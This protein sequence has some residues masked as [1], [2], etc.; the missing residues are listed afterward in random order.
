MAKTNFL[1]T[2]SEMIKKQLNDLGISKIVTDTLEPI[3]DITIIAL[4][5]VVISW[6]LYIIARTALKK[7]L[8]HKEYIF[9]KSILHFNVLKKI[10]HILFPIIV[11]WLLPLAFIESPLLQHYLESIL[12][13]YTVVAITITITALLDT[14]GETAFNN[15][16]Y[17]NRPIKGFVQIAKMIIYAISAI[18]VVSIIINKSPLYLIGGLGAFA[19]VFMLITKDSIMGFVG[20]YLLLENDMIRL[21]DWIEVPGSCI[22]GI[23][24]DISL[25]IVKV[26]N[27]DNT[28]A[29]IPPYTLINQSF[30]NW[31]GIDELGARRIVRN[32]F[33]KLDCIQPATITFLNEIKGFDKELDEY[34]EKFK[35]ADNIDNLIHSEINGTIESN[36][37]IFRAYSQIY[38][39]RHPLLR[40]DLLTMVRTLDITSNGLPIQFYCFAVTTDW[41]SYEAI[42][43]EIIEH[44]ISMMPKFGLYAAQNPTSYDTVISGFVE[45]N[46]DIE[47]IDGMPYGM[48]KR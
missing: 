21:G 43:T 13:I 26:R 8:K 29:T 19:A 23:V 7:V 31:R 46:R 22:N 38:L 20:G 42:S 25:T 28:I 18:I 2:I 1:H 40:H 47:N 12:A 37:G 4:I 24:T 34:I 3:I 41:K 45:G 16:K 30:I 17:H 14:L 39:R 5:S 32:I 48:M 44:L 10:A 36:I 9:L 11:L 27:F 6:L 15:T 33:I 35:S